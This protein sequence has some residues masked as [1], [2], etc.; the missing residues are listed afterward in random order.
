MAS[1]FNS[2]LAQFAALTAAMNA[3]ALHRAGLLDD[4]ER[5]SP[6]TFLDVAEG[7]AEQEGSEAHQATVRAI[8]ECLPPD[9]F[10]DQ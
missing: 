1:D 10:D 5:G 3:R 9:P 7:Y 8:R 2:A 4:L 6:H